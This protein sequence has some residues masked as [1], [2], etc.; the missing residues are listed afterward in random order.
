MK[1][2]LRVL[3]YTFALPR[4]IWWLVPLGAVALFLATD[5]RVEKDAILV[6]T[7]RPWLAKRIRWNYA[8]GAAWLLH[9]N[10]SATTRAHE[11]VHVRQAEDTMLAGFILGLIV[12]IFSS[13]PAWFFLIWIGES[14]LR[15]VGGWLG[16]VLR[17]GHVYYDSEHERS[18]DAQTDLRPDGKGGVTSWL[19]E[20]ESHPHSF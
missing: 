18:A 14:P 6:C 8:I 1:T 13:E 5:L 9:P 19:A 11:G 4:F 20:H 17:G 2:F 15:V 12:A 7:W 16:A 10:A 3:L